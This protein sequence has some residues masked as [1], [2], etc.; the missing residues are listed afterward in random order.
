MAI[1]NKSKADRFFVSTLLAAIPVALLWIAML[2]PL[3]DFLSGLAAGMILAAAAIM[4]INRTADEYTLAVWHAGTSAGFAACVAWLVFDAFVGGFRHEAIA[5]GRLPV[6]IAVTV[7][8]MVVG[9]KRLGLR[10]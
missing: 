6:L 10:S 2:Q 5:T 9:G 3:P 7:F 8:L 4:V 1:F